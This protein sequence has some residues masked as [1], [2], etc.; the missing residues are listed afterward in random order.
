MILQQ[1]LILLLVRFGTCFVTSSLGNIV[2]PIFKNTR[3][4]DTQT[5]YAVCQLQYEL[6][7]KHFNYEYQKPTKFGVCPYTRWKAHLDPS[8]IA[9][10]VEAKLLLGITSGLPDIYSQTVHDATY[11]FD[12]DR[13]IKVTNKRLIRETDALI[14]QVQSEEMTIP[15]VVDIREKLGMILH[16][17]QDFYS[18]TNWVES[19]QKGI[20]ENIGFSEEFKLPLNEAILPACKECDTPMTPEERKEFKNLMNNPLYQL[21]LNMF[22]WKAENVYVCRD[23]I[24]LNDHLH[25]GHVAGQFH[26]NKEQQCS[27]GGEINMNPRELNISNLQEEQRTAQ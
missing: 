15:V 1:F 7:K 21:P 14:R 4:H 5:D 6:L 25:T 24:I 16:T 20:A 26:D 8:V 19:K 13:M 3:F 10:A 9:E 22:N 18:H 11:H 17:L 2:L 27:H 12:N 23:N